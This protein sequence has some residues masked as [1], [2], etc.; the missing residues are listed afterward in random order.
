M[1]DLPSRSRKGDRH[2]AGQ[3]FLDLKKDPGR[4][5]REDKHNEAPDGPERLWEGIEK[6]GH[7][8]TPLLY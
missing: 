7:S 8:F 4:A 6:E 3:W 5:C 1:D 2:S